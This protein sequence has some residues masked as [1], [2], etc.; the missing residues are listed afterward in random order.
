MAKI[1]LTQRD[2]REALK[3]VVREEMQKE[4][5]VKQQL[6]L[7]EA[8]KINYGD[9]CP[10]CKAVVSLISKNGEWKEVGKNLY[11]V[12]ACPACKEE[13]WCRI[14]EQRSSDSMFA[15]TIVTGVFMKKSDVIRDKTQKTQSNTEEKPHPAPKVFRNNSIDTSDNS[16]KIYDIKMYGDTVKLGEK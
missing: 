11:L 3:D 4:N 2:V 16:V 7:K 15:E 12:Q 5:A 6:R 13:I 14:I 10:Y 9:N 1:S 8:K